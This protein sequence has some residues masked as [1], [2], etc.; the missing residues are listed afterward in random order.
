MTQTQTKG[1]KAAT[2]SLNFASYSPQSSYGIRDFA[3]DAIHVYDIDVWVVFLL[4]HSV[5]HREKLNL[6]KQAW[7]LLKDEFVLEVPKNVYY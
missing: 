4:L 1:L 2:L 7:V 5:C 6:S 3:A